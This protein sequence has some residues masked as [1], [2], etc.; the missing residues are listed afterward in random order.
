MDALEVI[1]FDV[2]L[3]TSSGGYL[4][5]VGKTVNQIGTGGSIST[6]IAT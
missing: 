3:S 2:A 4:S 5:W 1:A 6:D